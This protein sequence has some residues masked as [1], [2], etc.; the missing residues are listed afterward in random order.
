LISRISQIFNVE[1][2]GIALCAVTTRR[3]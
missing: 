2:V 3:S 1:G